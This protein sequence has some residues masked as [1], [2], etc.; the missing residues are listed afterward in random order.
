MPYFQDKDKKIIKL[1]SRFKTDR[2]NMFCQCLDDSTFPIDK[3]A[4]FISSNPDTCR[5]LSLDYG[6][7]HDRIRRNLIDLISLFHFLETNGYIILCDAELDNDVIIYK[8]EIYP[9]T[10]KNK[11]VLNK[12]E[13]STSYKVTLDEKT[14]VFINETS[15]EG[16]RKGVSPF[17]QI[18]VETTLTPLNIGNN[19]LKPIKK[20][21]CSYVYPTTKLYELIRND[22]KT[23]EELYNQ[24]II[25]K[26]DKQI[27]KA[28]ITIL[29]AILSLLAS[30]LLPFLSRICD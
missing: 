24:S 11:E 25:D 26:A 8:K 6:D 5:I 1:I 14:D 10:D 23:S 30:I 29:I 18:D 17:I 2:P 21:L 3:S 7:F 22:F 19:L 20:I 12:N 4:V 13:T 28:N 27:D 9:I 16:Y 15:Y